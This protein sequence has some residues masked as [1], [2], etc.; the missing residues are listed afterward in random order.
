M[1][2]ANV[3][4]VTTPLTPELSRARIGSTATFA[5]AGALCA[6]WTVRIPA[7]TDKLHLDPAGVGTAVLV[8]GIGAMITMQ[9]ARVAITRLGSRRTLLLAAPGSAVLLAGIGL[10]PTYPWLL[11]ASALFG[12]AFGALDI[13]MNAQVAALERSTGRHLM[14]GAH[15]G[16]SIGS[17][18]GGA[19]GAL[20]AYLQMTFTQAVVGMAVLGLP[21]ALA[22]LPTY[23]PDPPAPAEVR[24]ARARLP[25]V[26][27]LIGA[28]TC[29]SFI[30]EG[31]IADWSGLYLRNELSAREAVAA[32]AYPVFEAA[33]IVGRTFGDRV[34]RR[35]GSRAMLTGG[36]VG[37]ATS[38][39]I[40]VAAPH[41]WLALVGFFLVGLAI[42]TVVP[43]TFSIAGGLDDAGAGIAQAGAMGY[44]GML[45]GPVAI[46]YVANATSVRTGLVISVA[47]GV[48]ITILAR[49]VS[50]VDAS[51]QVQAV[52]MARHT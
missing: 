31:S 23:V 46:G 48:V 7:L 12:A 43:L 10:A 28:V 22:M 51:T 44:G 41:W 6:V 33:M 13:G 3:Q 4:R 8:F 45:I 19:L 16:W 29:A 47:L 49:T 14:N 18:L 38:F 21:A 32:L 25:R 40:V 30:I 27:Y 37:A 2:R 35:V 34:R 26:I 17:V 20:S 42:C 11:V 50:R 15:A 5:L 1:G 24:A 52:D 39:A 36:G 9:L